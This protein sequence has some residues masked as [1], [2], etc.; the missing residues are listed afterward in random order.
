SGQNYSQHLQKRRAKT[1]RMDP[2]QP[3]RTR[4]EK[5]GE[6]EGGKP[7]VIA[8]IKKDSA[9]ARRPSHIRFDRCEK[10][11]QFTNCYETKQLRNDYL[12]K[13][14]RCRLRCRRTGTS[15]LHGAWFQAAG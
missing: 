14:R 3:R 12:V 15:R 1:G 9:K 11:W 5:S 2:R 8:G 6:G 13:R 4:P 7:G 10:F